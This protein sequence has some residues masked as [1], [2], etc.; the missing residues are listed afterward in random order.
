MYFAE[1]YM[2]GNAVL[3]IDAELIQLREHLRLVG[4][5]DASTPISGGR[6]GR[7]HKTNALL[8]ATQFSANHECRF[9]AMAAIIERIEQH[10]RDTARTLP[11]GCAMNAPDP[12][13]RRREVSNEPGGDR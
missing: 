2:Y 8:I 11:G 4:D 5:G 10:I 12:D 9:D 7:Q 13:S 1:F 3:G 6:M